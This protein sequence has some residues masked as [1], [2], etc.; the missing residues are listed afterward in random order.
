MSLLSPLIEEKT[1]R[2][3]QHQQLY[4]PEGFGKHPT[5]VLPIIY[6]F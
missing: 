4:N 6:V 2:I 1:F 3:S 5:D